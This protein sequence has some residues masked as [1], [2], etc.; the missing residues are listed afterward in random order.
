VNCATKFNSSV[1]D[2][3]APFVDGVRINS[4]HYLCKLI[5]SESSA[6]RYTL[7]VS[8]Y[9]K[10]NTIFYTLRVYATC[11][12]SLTKIGSPYQHTQKVSLTT[13]QNIFPHYRARDVCQS[14]LFLVVCLTSEL[15]SELC[16]HF[17]QWLSRALSCHVFYKWGLLFLC[18]PVP[19]CHVLGKIFLSSYS[20]MSK[21]SPSL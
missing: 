12:F 7:V 9:E 18:T 14:K 19:S 16:P 5:L 21:L 11:P 2:D 15:G 10:M 3:P 13:K 1:A 20:V 8:Q 4:P 17:T 6:H